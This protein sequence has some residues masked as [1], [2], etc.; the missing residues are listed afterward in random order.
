MGCESGDRGLGGGAGTRAAPTAMLRALI[1][2][3]LWRGSLPQGPQSTDYSL[4]V[5]AQIKVLRGI[6]G[7]IP[8]RFTYPSWMDVPYTRDSLHGYWFK[9]PADYLWDSPVA[10]SDPS[11]KVSAEARGRF[12]LSGALQ[13]G[14][15]SLD[16]QDVQTS[17][18][19]T[20]VFRVE[21]GMFKYTYKP[22][23]ERQHTQPQVSVLDGPI[24]QAPWLDATPGKL[25]AGNAVNVTCWTPSSCSEPPP[26]VAWTGPLELPLA[27]ASRDAGGTMYSSERGFRP[28]AGDDGRDLVCRVSY[29]GF[30]RITAQASVQLQIV[31]P[32][33]TPEVNGT[34]RRDGHADAP[35]DLGINVSISG[36]NGR[37][38][39]IIQGNNVK[40]KAV[41]GG[42]VW[43]LCSVDSS[44]P[45]QL[46]WGFRGRDLNTSQLGAGGSEGILQLL[47]L[48]PEHA[49]NYQCQATNDLG[50][51]QGGF[52]LVVE[53]SPRP[54]AGPDPGLWCKH[55]SGGLC[56][57][58]SLRAEPPAQLH[59]EVNGATVP[60]KDHQTKG[61]CTDSAMHWEGPGDSVV[62]IGSNYLG[63][64]ALQGSVHTLAAEGSSRLLGLG[65]TIGA[66]A[67]L[68]LLLLIITAL[69]LWGWRLTAPQ[70]SKKPPDLREAQADDINLVY[71]NVP[72]RG[73]PNPA[74]P[75]DPHSQDETP[76]AN[77]DFSRLPAPSTPCDTPATEYAQIRCMDPPPCRA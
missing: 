14:D 47:K 72:T 29:P 16:I 59:W 58:C 27:P 50:G 61:N 68:L 60:G 6:C 1:L 64:Y 77:I 8:C 17:D 10:T 35:R 42:S 26:S 46:S 21:R 54:A 3:L 13:A 41:E 39:K 73:P 20:Y 2:A 11:R 24:I 76:Y 74:A 66:G 57:H 5:P 25:R 63:F 48:H 12:R 30:K 53:Y 56:C 32:P 40:L 62:C 4:T 19:G 75:L 23:R 34:L 33:G 71:S 49:G 38:F 7:H 67:F 55:E 70:R 22:N 65:A 43:A 51:I 28:V 36:A 69:L 44:P 15:C 45:A 37:N 52:Q 31:Y 18:A 9:E